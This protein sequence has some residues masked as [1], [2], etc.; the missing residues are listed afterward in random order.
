MSKREFYINA[1]YGSNVSSIRRD[2]LRTFYIQ[3]FLHMTEYLRMVLKRERD[4]R[5]KGALVRKNLNNFHKTRLM[6]N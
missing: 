5:K 3:S 6:Q 2:N 4:K 1:G